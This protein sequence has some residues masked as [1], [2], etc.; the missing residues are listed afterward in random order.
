M[1][2]AYGQPKFFTITCSLLRAVTFNELNVKNPDLLTVSISF[3]KTKLANESILMKHLLLY[4]H[5]LFTVSATV[6]VCEVLSYRKK[7]GIQLPVVL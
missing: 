7:K 1:I 4:L 6:C 3:S 2:P 5:F